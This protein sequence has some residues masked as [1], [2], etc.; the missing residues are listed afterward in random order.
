MDTGEFPTFD[1]DT[2]SNVS[3]GE[4]YRGQQ[5][6]EKEFGRVSRRLDRM[7]EENIP[8]RLSNLEK[9]RDWAVRIVMSGVIV[10]LLSLLFVTG[11]TIA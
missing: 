1:P 4:V 11:G 5:R 7:F 10:G 6:L 8:H 3:M 9:Q 2:P